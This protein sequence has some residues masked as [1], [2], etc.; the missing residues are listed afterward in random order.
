MKS[1]K[2][3]NAR[4]LKEAAALLA[5]Y[6]GNARI[7]AGGTDLLGGMRDGCELDY[8]E[9][10]INIK[11]IQSLDYI[12]AGARGL[13]IGAL[14]RLAEIVKS[15]VI[16]Q[17]YSLLAEAA[18]SIA[19]PNLRNMA[20]VG[21]NLAQDVRCWYYRYPQQIGGPIV[22]LRKGGRVCSALAGD[23]RY[24][25]IFGGAPVAE[26]QCASHCPAKI[27][28]PGFLRQ[29]RKGNVAEAA[30][31]LMDCNPIPAIT[32]RVCPIFCE[33]HCNRSE[34]D[35]PVAI[36]SVERG[37]GDYILDH[38]ADFFAPPLN[39]S[40]K[41]V[42]VVGA[43]PA[44][45]AAAF[46]LRRSGHQVTIY[47]RMPEPGGML[48]YSIP[49]YRLPKEVV[50]KQIRALQSMGVRF[51]SNVEIG[52][53]VAGGTPTLMNSDA[54]LLAGGT[55]E[56]LKLGVPGEQGQG[57]YYALEFLRRINSGEKLELGAKVIVIG[58]G[59]VA[60]DA[61]RTARRLGAS[62]VH[63]VCLETRELAS[64]DRMPALDKE[65]LD[66]EEEGVVI[67]SSLGIR[68]IV[69]KSGKVAGLETKR[70]ISV[71]EPDGRFNP[72]YDVTS[73]SLSLPGESIIIAIGQVYDL[74]LSSFKEGADGIFTAGDMASGASTVIQAV[75]SAQKIVQEI[76]V[77][78]N[79][80]QRKAQTYT[81]SEYAESCFDDIPRADTRETPAGQR[82]QSIAAEDV[83]GLSLREIETEARR[84]V[85]CGCLAIGPSDLAIALAA[86]NATVVTTRRTLAAQ[87]FFAAS[88]TRSTVLEQDEV[89]KEIRI[90]KPP[91]NSRQTYLKFTLRKPVDFALVSVASVVTSKSGVCSDA[92]IILGAV[93]PAPFRARAA[94]VE[95]KGKHIDENCAAEAAKLALENAAPLSMNAYKV[96]IAKA[97]VKRSILSN[98][99]SAISDQLETK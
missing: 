75:S 23:N 64:K 53:G 25:S 54:V 60:V 71:R 32:G 79:G 62:E 94:E 43:G 33:P 12:K 50:R 85:N 22:C 37:V 84:C 87:E 98:Q 83:Q 46:Y 48:L 13:R 36:H 78:L 80:G 97:L 39:E 47:D 10:L 34:Y 26:R 91:G 9:A 57:V 24:H 76:E 96:E 4:S 70:C 17:D 35:D 58:G 21:G 65:I 29:A 11:G 18:H 92:R 55:W 77:Y 93:A 51:E 59:S 86:L 38:A 2:H 45:L 52:S 95:I 20:T 8:P 90:P 1:F 14:T 72:Q 30:R 16:K 99:L 42:A 68:E 5:K 41:T 15:P 40:G 67:H 88:A 44:G 89:I 63:L 7:N 56:S 69:L 27:N 28:I 73:P 66:A 19:S 81:E 6:N 61:A 3:H 31:I 74:S 49:P 82:I